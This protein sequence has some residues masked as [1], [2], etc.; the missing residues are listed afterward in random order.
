[1]FSKY[2][3]H[4][5]ASLF[6]T[7]NS[8]HRTLLLAVGSVCLPACTIYAHAAAATSTTLQVTDPVVSYRTPVTLTATVTTSGAAV[9]PGLVKFCDASS[10]FCEDTA[11]LGTA[12][13]QSNGTATLKKSLPVGLHAVYAVFAGTQASAASSSR[14]QSVVVYSTTKLVSTTALAAP[15]S[16]S[17]QL[18]A[19]VTG[20]GTPRLTGGVSFR[21][22]ATGRNLGTASL[23]SSVLNFGASSPQVLPDDDPAL[24]NPDTASLGNIVVADLNGDGIPDLFFNNQYLGDGSISTNDFYAK[25]GDPA[26]PGSYLPGTAYSFKNNSMFS[27]VPYF[28]ISN[29]IAIGDFNE[30]GLPDIAVILS[31][32]ST[33]LPS[34]ANPGI[35]QLLMNDPQNPGHFLTT[36]TPIPIGNNPNSIV[37]GDFNQDG[38]PDLAVTN[39]AEANVGV[40]FNTPADP[41]QFQAMT[42]VALGPNTDYVQSIVVGDFNGDGVQD[43]AVNDSHEDTSTYIQTNWIDVLYGNSANPGQFSSPTRLSIDSG[44][45]SDDFLAAGDLDKDG[46]PDLLV[47]ARQNVYVTLS[48]P[49]LATQWTPLVNY[50]LP[51]S[52]SQLGYAALGDVNGDGWLDI[53]GTVATY[54]QGSFSYGVAAFSGDPTHPGSFK[55][56]VTYSLDS[57]TSF[58]PTTFSAADINGDGLSDWLV[59]GYSPTVN[60]ITLFSQPTRTASASISLSDVA[61]SSQVY[62]QYS[63]DF[64]YSGSKS[65]PVSTGASTSVSPK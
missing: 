33:I 20:Y 16:D 21:D 29:P 43:L 61:G 24:T 41:G 10:S 8:L 39:S 15:T 5:S 55:P 45:S 4:R 42:S 53:M 57:E 64:I 31:A 14:P 58:E 49:A 35:V 19:T 44:Y 59:G 3:R 11:L 1:M 22:A 7:R 48:R 34:V 37:V 52:S 50:T 26:H 2:C 13:L 62:A 65:D 27:N 47:D 28:Q 25:L 46:L 40:L 30:D 9:N 17:P 18:T 12:Q 6:F 32:A 63:G 54:S 51:D 36:A 23:S 56:A 60:A 38:L